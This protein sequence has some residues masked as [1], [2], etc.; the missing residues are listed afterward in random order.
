MKIHILL[1]LLVDALLSLIILI[2][3]RH[4]LV[5]LQVI[6]QA[7]QYIPVVVLTTSGDI[8]TIGHMLNVIS[9]VEHHRLINVPV[10]LK[11]QNPIVIGKLHTEQEQLIILL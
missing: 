6:I 11:L 10:Q 2:L 4:R 7:I 5:V 8:L 9:V 1:Q 3:T